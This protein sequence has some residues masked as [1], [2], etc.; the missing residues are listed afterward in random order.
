[1]EQNLPDLEFIL[2]FC[3][4]LAMLGNACQVQ[5][6]PKKEKDKEEDKG[7]EPKEKEESTEPLKKVE[8]QNS[9]GGKKNK[10][11]NKKKE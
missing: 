9:Q 11:K 2:Y 6:C 7:A 5:E 4:A 1:M 3:I 8:K 10:G